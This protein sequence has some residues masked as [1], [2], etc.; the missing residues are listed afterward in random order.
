MRRRVRRLLLLAIG[1]LY[2]ASVPWYRPAGAEAEIWLGLPDW[3]LVAMLCYA[4]VALL[5]AAAWLLTEIPE[6]PGPPAPAPAETGGPAREHRGPG[7][8]EP[9]A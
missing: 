7:R 8:S 4:G 1:L 2:V 9:M 6:E 3:V 5:N